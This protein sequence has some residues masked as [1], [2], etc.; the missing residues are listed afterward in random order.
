MYKKILTIALLVILPFF[1]TACTLQDL[2]V[3]GKYFGNS[4]GSG[5]AATVNIWGLWEAPEVMDTLIAKYK[6]TNPNVTVN[7]DNRSVMKA[8]QY[9]DTITTRM[10]QGGDVPDIVLVHSSWTARAASLLNPM[11]ASVMDQ[12]TYAKNFYPSAVQSGIVNGKIYAVPVYYDG[13]V[14]VYN[15]KHFAEIDQATPPTSWEEFRML[16]LN[17]T[18]RDKDGNLI[19]AGAAI[20]TS[21]NTD[22]FLDILGLMFAQ[23]G[24]SLPSGLDSKQAQDALS[25]YAAFVN[26]DKV[27][28]TSFPEASAAF[29]KEQ[30]SMI[31][32]PTW[33]LL[34]ILRV[35]PDLD[36]GVAPVPQAQPSNPVSLGSFWMYAVP[37]KAV[38]K[39][40]AWNFIKYMT[41]EQTEL[42]MF[43]E[44]SK[45]RAYGAPYA[46]ASLASQA[47]SGAASK[48][49]K[50][51][52]DTAPFSAT[53][54]LEGR[55]GNTAISAA[56]GDAI[57]AVTDPDPTKR[58]SPA[59]ALKTAKEKLL[60]P[61]Q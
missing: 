51:L 40:A 28:S 1:V 41:T 12:Q 60:Q 42:Q 11:P 61:V 47:S 20:G 5:T 17:L 44:A 52:L 10:T 32:V 30:V 36:I 16:A 3:I 49:I 2:P 14:L 23:A 26:E 13:L 8:D 53:S 54:M 7:Y 9:K 59:D 35:R 56:I 31:F 38:H 39:D 58:I 24:V 45:Y 43:S 27:W 15:K 6:E 34:D 46:L 50:P 25:F 55:A 21:N 22:F 19:R 57:T 18:Q 33:S 48:Y 29:A 37:E 4:G